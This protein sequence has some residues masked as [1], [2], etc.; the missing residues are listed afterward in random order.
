MRER[1]EQDPRLLIELLFAFRDVGAWDDVLRAAEVLA[2]AARDEERV[3]Q[4]LALAHVR[5]GTAVDVEQA[6]RLLRRFLSRHP[7]DGT[8]WSLLRALTVS[9]GHRRG[10]A[11]RST[12]RSTPTNVRGKSTGTR[13]RRANSVHSSLGAATMNDSNRYCPWRGPSLLKSLPAGG[14]TSG[15]SRMHLNWRLSLVTRRRI[16]RCKRGKRHREN[17]ALASFA[18]THRQRQLDGRHAG[19]RW[20]GCRDLTSEREPEWG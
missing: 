2:E 1:S 10:S 5:R 3:V 14:R 9:G 7:E 8:G 19:S 17:G 13:M 15:Q 20:L 11:T 12:S 4:L 6:I 18:N 16:W